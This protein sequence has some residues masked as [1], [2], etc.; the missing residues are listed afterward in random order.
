MRKAEAAGFILPPMDFEKYA[1]KKEEPAEEPHEGATELRSENPA[2]WVQVSS[3]SDEGRQPA[4]Q[5]LSPRI[6]TPGIGPSGGR[7]RLVEDDEDKQDA[8]KEIEYE[9]VKTVPDQTILSPTMLTYAK[10]NRDYTIPIKH[11]EG[12]PAS[13]TSALLAR[14]AGLKDSGSVASLAYSNDTAS[15]SAFDAVGQGTRLPRSSSMQKGHFRKSSGVL[16]SDS[17]LA[18]STP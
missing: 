12:L 15:S 1:A 2:F 17:I 10:E 9:K 16:L 6:G 3:T 13:G 14:R 5:D 4:L 7:I 18:E 8:K 11:V